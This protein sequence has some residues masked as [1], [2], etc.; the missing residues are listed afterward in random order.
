MDYIFS[1]LRG[2]GVAKASSIVRQP[3]LSAHV[4]SLHGT[5]LYRLSFRFTNSPGFSARIGV[6]QHAAG[7]G[8]LLL[9]RGPQAQGA[10]VQLHQRRRQ[11][12]PAPPVVAGARAADA[13]LARRGEWVILFL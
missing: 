12:E 6:Q 8:V 10:A 3:R 13:A 4:F 9:F 5:C 7:V 1:V 2:V 11:H